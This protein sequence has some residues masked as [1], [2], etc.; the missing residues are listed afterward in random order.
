MLQSEFAAGISS[1]VRSARLEE[2]PQDWEPERNPARDPEG[3]NHLLGPRVCWVCFLSLT[4]PGQ[5]S[6]QK[7]AKGTQ[8]RF[9]RRVQAPSEVKDGKTWTL[10]SPL[11]GFQHP[12]V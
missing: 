6:Q 11:G 10:T 4:L 12:S 8:S 9:P 1:L 5:E 3:I 2:S 7:A